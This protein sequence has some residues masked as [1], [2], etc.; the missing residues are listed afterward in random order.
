MR[1]RSP[2]SGWSFMPD[3]ELIDWWEHWRPL[4]EDFR[5]AIEEAPQGYKDAL[6]DRGFVLD[7]CPS[8]EYDR[9]RQAHD[10]ICVIC[11]KEVNA[12]A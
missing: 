6:K 2:S 4:Y 3:A 1:Q 8:C 11:R 7:N 10:Y 9:V 12:L 5:V